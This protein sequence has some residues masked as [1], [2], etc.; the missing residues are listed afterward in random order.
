MR[1]LEL[2]SPARNLEIG[3]AAIDC[4]ADAVYIAGPDFGA[5]KDAGNSFEDIASLCSYAHRFGARV[6]VTYNIAIREDELEELHS[7]MLKAQDAGAD[8]FIVR[9][10]RIFEMKD[11]TVP[12]HASTQCAIRDID[13]AKHFEA[14]GS[15]RIVLE[16]ELSLDTVR[17]ICNG[18]NCE[19]EFFVHGALCVC[20]SGECRLSEYLNGRSADRGECIQACR[21]LYDLEDASGNVLVRDK[22]LLSLKDY[23]LLPRLEELAEAGVIS[24]K[25]EGRLK[26]ASY[27]KNVVRAYSMALDEIV[28]KHPDT[29]RRAS[30]GTV[31]GGFTPS[32]EKTFN[33][34]YTELFL[35]GKRGQ[36]SSMNAPKSMGEEIGTVIDV[37]SCGQ[38]MSD[39]RI[40]FK[41][42]DTSLANGDGFA[43]VGKGGKITGFRGDKCDGCHI[44]AKSTDGLRRGTVLYRNISAEF[45]KSIENQSPRRELRVGVN[46]TI[47]G[48]YVLEINAASEDGRKVCSTF[49]ADVDS[50]TDKERSMAMLREQ[51]SKRSGQ[52]VFNVEAIDV[53][54]KGSD[55]PLLSASTINSIRRLLASDLDDYPCGTIPLARG[56]RQ[57][58]VIASK[59]DSSKTEDEPLMLSKYCIRYELGLCPRSK[60]HGSALSGKNIHTS[61]AK[62]GDRLFLRNN[63]R[64][65]TLRFD[66]SRC[67]MRVE[68]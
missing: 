46:L 24:F 53:M 26:N 9:D 8:A 1:C 45:E 3:I 19:V 41:K 68:K 64:R 6:F 15:A 4:G 34:G 36:W 39:I 63:N 5:R 10:E 17:K 66:C 28:A 18:V 2:L 51:L 22:A 65:L 44:W 37:R 50:A 27:V 11:I 62:S 47:S 67:E 56:T 16:R 42:K 23:N 58:G 29:Y 49:H 20:Y 52:Y 61:D 14:L 13:R 57:E 59:E 12:L 31:R 40:S 54:T 60:N 38:G 21:S 30:F 55:I 48:H 25:I 35:D 43:F 7:Q 32:L 33:R